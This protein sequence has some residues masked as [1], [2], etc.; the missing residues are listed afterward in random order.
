MVGIHS[1]AISRDGQRWVVK[2]QHDH[3]RGVSS[4]TERF[5]AMSTSPPLTS[6]RPAA[7]VA[8]ASRA[9]SEGEPLA[10]PLESVWADSEQLAEKSDAASEAREGGGDTAEVTTTTT[11]STGATDGKTAEATDADV[12]F[13]DLVVR[14]AIG[15]EKNGMSKPCT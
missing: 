12:V 7:T 5:A 6:D 1:L 14:G 13:Y 11:A 8:A 10:E 4:L 9:A 2:A 15:R 3:G